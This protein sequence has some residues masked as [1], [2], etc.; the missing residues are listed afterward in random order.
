MH[1]C[2]TLTAALAGG[3]VA[4]R[5][6]LSAPGL[7]DLRSEAQVHPASPP[8]YP[9]AS[10][11]ISLHDCRRHL[12]YRQVFDFVTRLV[13]RLETLRTGL[14]FCDALSR[15]VMEL[16]VTERAVT[17]RVVCVVCVACA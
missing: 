3:G 10:H 1:M 11:L 16:V 14:T 17:E 13:K 15:A 6:A 12:C 4:G 5:D 2:P 7:K 8:L 9:C